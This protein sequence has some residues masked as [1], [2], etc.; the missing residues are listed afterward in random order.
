MNLFVPKTYKVRQRI[1]DFLSERRKAIDRKRNDVNECAFTISEI[2][3]QLKIKRGLVDN[4]M[5]VLYKLNQV[6]TIR[7]NTEENRFFINEVGFYASSSKE[8]FNEGKLLNSQIVSN[9]TNSFFQIITGIIALYT[10]YKTYTT[11]DAQNIKLEQVQK[12]ILKLEEQSKIRQ[13]LG[14]NLTKDTL[15]LN[16]QKANVADSLNR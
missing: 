8:P 1:L 6:G 5:D 10:V 14:L 2:S 7:D 9:Y 12:S 4:Q 13:T 16:P 3:E 11:I 15:I